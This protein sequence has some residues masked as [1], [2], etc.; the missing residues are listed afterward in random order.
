MVKK[1]GRKRIIR[2][3]NSPLSKKEESFAV[4]YVKTHNKTQAAIESGYSSK[5]A[6]AA[7]NRA[8]KK[9]NVR[10][11]IEELEKKICKA[12]GIEVTDVLTI[13]KSIG[14]FNI[15]EVATYNGE[16]F[17]FKPFD[18][19]PEGS[20]KAI[21]SVKQVTRYV[22]GGTEK[23]L[24]IKFESKLTAAKALGD[25]LGMFSGYEQLVRTATI[26]GKKLV[27]AD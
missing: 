26:Y 2:T 8:F 14:Q 15:K 3:K 12:A 16:T 1:A 5:T 13:F 18:Q 10:A 9:L 6:G 4:A 22:E 17:Q 23:T 24:E 27:D 11:R 19:W 7:G 25:Y 21:A 20:E